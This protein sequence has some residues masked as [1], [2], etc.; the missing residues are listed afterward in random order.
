ME[1]SDDEVLEAARIAQVVEFAGDGSGMK[2]YLVK[3]GGINLSGGQ[4]QRI[5]IARAIVKQ[6]PILLWD[7]ATSALD[8]ITRSIVESAVDEGFKN[9]T[10]LTISH[11]KTAL[12]NSDRVLFLE[13]GN[14]AG[15]A[16]KNKLVDT[17]KRYKEFFS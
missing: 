8:E 1:A 13:D 15:F 10:I 16:D 2:D 14:L 7:E 12:K 4:R 3:H 17:S 5:A 11:N 9:K 6:A